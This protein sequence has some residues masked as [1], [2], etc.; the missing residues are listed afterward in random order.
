MR[1]VDGRLKRILKRDA[2]TREKRQ[3]TLYEPF[4]IPIGGSENLFNV[5]FQQVSY[6][7]LTCTE[8]F[9]ITVFHFCPLT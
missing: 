8:A 5:C 7:R 6:Q 1:K 3:V 9:N 4:T 2:A